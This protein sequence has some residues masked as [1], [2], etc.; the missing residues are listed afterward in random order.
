MIA[1]I[2][3][4]RHILLVLAIA[5]FHMLVWERG[6]AGDGWGYFSTLESIVEDRDLDLTNN[7]YSVT[8]GLSYNAEVQRWVAQ[9]PPGLAFFDAPFYLAGD[10]LYEEGLLRPSIEADKMRAAYEGVDSRILARIIFVVLAHNVYALLALV[11]IYGTLTRLGFSSGWAAF[12][13]AL[14]FF[15]SPL[16]FYAQNGMSHAVSCFMAAASAF[17]LSGL[18]AEPLGRARRWFWLGMTVGGGAIVR[19]ASVFLSIPVGVVLLVL[20]RKRLGSLFGKGLLFS[21]GLCAV[22]WILPVYLKIQTGKW[23]YSTYSPNWNFDISAPPI[24]NVLLHE[25]HGFLL[26]HPLYWFALAGIGVAFFRR[27]GI[28]PALRLMSGAGLV[29]LL[30][31]GFVYGI[32]FAWWGGNSY[33]Q[34]FLTDLIPFLAPGLALFLTQGWRAWRVTVAIILTAISYVFFL[35]SNA[36]LVYD[37]VPNG[38]GQT[39]LDYRFILDQGMSFMEIRSRLA[40]AS[41]TLPLIQKHGI[42]F[43]LVIGNLLLAYLWLRSVDIGGRSARRRAAEGNA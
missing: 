18:C 41:F 6:L 1:R 37:I 36:G 25:R 11:L 34:R 19:Y 22:G 9:Y 14:S 32:W 40:D 39:L 23:F 42:A 21:A 12:V 29:A 20:E 3:R 31:L 10:F 8:N 30:S 17:V 24:L 7:R 5:G 27:E 38:P 2:A 43:L 4:A 16:H 26:Y 15:G 33:S 35:L 28:D 13:T